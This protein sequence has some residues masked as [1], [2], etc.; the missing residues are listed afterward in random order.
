M[1]FHVLFKFFQFFWCIVRFLFHLFAIFITVLVYWYNI[2]DISVLLFMFRYSKVYMYLHLFSCIFHF[3]TSQ[4]VI[5]SP[6]ISNLL[7]NFNCI[8]GA[9]LIRY[10]HW[11]IF[12]GLEEK[13]FWCFWY[14]RFAIYVLVQQSIYVLTCL[15]N[16][17]H[18]SYI[19]TFT[20]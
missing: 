20:G 16:F 1:Y 15:I 2:F 3:F 17:L 6:V 13:Y 5:H 8:T 4:K 19:P 7:S 14:K 11:W 18:L 9:I 10:S 12:D